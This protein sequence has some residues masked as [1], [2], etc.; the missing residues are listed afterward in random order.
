MAPIKFEE[1]VKEQLERREMQPSAGSWE[2]LSSRLEEAENRPKRKWW[3]SVAAAMIVL[4]IASLIFTDQQSG[5]E[6][7][8]VENPAEMEKSEPQKPENI[9]KR[10][11]V[12]SEE[13]TDVSPGKMVEDK[14]QEEVSAGM[15]EN[16]IQNKSSE[17]Q[18]VQNSS[19]ERLIIEP[20]KMEPPGT[21]SES[22]AQYSEQINELI[23]KVAQQEEQEG[24]ISEAEV[25]RL[26]AEAANEI[27]S[28]RNFSQ[29]G[30]SAEA[31][32]ADVEYE[33]DQSFRQEVFE[34]L[35]EGFLKA[36][37]AIA[38]RNE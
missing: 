11:E 27:S 33:M 24:D 4:A 23:A 16:R 30:V 9:E 28:A 8:V 10:V 3:I 13:K 38:T 2:K 21:D 17:S 34:V 31:L 19:E 7:P 14:P 20:V 29:G 6:T 25:N 18:L 36:R 22:P 12:A 15:S 37:T 26:L 35:K 5:I 32:L 1:H